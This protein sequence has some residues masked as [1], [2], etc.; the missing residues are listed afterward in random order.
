MTYYNRKPL[1]QRLFLLL[2]LCLSNTIVIYAQVKISIE[3]PKATYATKEAM[4]FRLNA[5]TGGEG[6]YEIYYDPR[7]PNKILKKGIL[8]LRPGRDS[9]I[10][11]THPNPGLVFFKATING[12]SETQVVS[13]DPLSIK[14]FDTEPSDFD[15]FWDTQ[16]TKLA[17]I[18][19]N[20]ILTSL[21]TLPNG[22]KLYML[23]LDQIDNRKVYGYLCIPAGTG[24]FPA[25]LSLPPFGTAPHQVDNVTTTD[26]S[27]QSKAISLTLSVHNAPPNVIDPNAYFPDDLNNPETVYNRYMVL[28]S[29][30]AIDYLHTRPDFNGSLG[31]CGISQGGGLAIMVGGLDK[32]VAAL[33]TSNP[34]SCEHQAWRFGQASGFPSYLKRA[35][36]LKMDSTIAIKSAKYHD[37][38]YFL[39][40]FKGNLRLLAG[41]KDDV[42][43]AVTGIAA[44]NQH[45]GQSALVHMTNTAHNNPWA[46]YWLGRFDFF[47]TYLKD[48]K[49]AFTAK[50]TITLN[51]G[52]DLVNVINP[53]IVLQGDVKGEAA[54][55]KNL[56]YKWSKI[57]GP[58]TVNFFTPNA[59]TTQVSFNREGSYLLRLTA[60]DDYLANDPIEGKYFTMTDYMMVQ[61]SKATAVVESDEAQNISIS[62]N[63]VQ[64]TLQIAWFSN[65]NYK[66]IKILDATG[67]QVLQ[68]NLDVLTKNHTLNVA[69]L[70][71]GFYLIEME[72]PKGGK[73]LK[74]MVKQ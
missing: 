69:T 58:G 20:P 62:P 33:M 65:E 51:A 55:I 61:V 64:S 38:I 34:A 4:Y 18:P 41:Y 49:Y 46:E 42:T 35:Y 71:G 26:I 22:S 10:F 6:S 23:Q 28:A 73:V 3:K 56:T 9:F 57:E 8:K 2:L 68:E 37:A 47:N 17:I 52:Q 74:R 59:L 15:A 30:R 67:R 45:R 72:N 54:V 11:Y 70:A 50:R 27:E 21:N 7:E 16:K 24:K 66:S 48:F 36:A 12:F 1:F 44:Y 32:R 43:P 19:Q 25:V 14:P 13:F 63:P 40:R 53:T 60:E 5:P 29:L 39:K 31:V